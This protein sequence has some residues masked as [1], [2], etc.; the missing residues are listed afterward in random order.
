[1]QVGTVLSCMP[2]CVPL[3]AVA[4]MDIGICSL[5]KLHLC[6][7]AVP[8]GLARMQRLWTY[9]CVRTSAL[10]ICVG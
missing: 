9:S 8:W 4:L 10:Q 2:S 1:M 6:I 7:G 5:G 3:V